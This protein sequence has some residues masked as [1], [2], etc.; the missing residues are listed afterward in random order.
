M[1]KIYIIAIIMVAVAIG[2]FIN[3]G[4]DMSTYSTF[5]QALV[6][7]GKVKVVG[8]LAKDKEMYYNPEKD[9]NYFS[10]YVRDTD[11][12]EKKVVL[13][14]EKPQDFELSEQIVLTGKM[15]GDEFH[16]SDMLMKCPSKYKDE[17]IY[18]KGEER[19]G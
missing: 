17:E 12:Q 4:K 18:I 8:Q 19:Q 5:S 16:A 9:P 15:K 1:K 2:L 14:Q 10:F 6:A 11:G 3:A 7:N 13:F